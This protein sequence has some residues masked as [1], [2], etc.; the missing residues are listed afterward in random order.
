MNKKKSNLRFSDILRGIYGGVIGSLCCVL[1]LVAVAAGLGFIPGIMTTPRYRIYF[2]AAGLILVLFLTWR[3]VRSSN[4]DTYRK[5][6]ILFTTLASFFLVVILF[7]YLITPI[8]SNLIAKY[9]HPNKN[10]PVSNSVATKSTELH[11]VTLKITGLTCPSCSSVIEGLVSK[12]NGV[13]KVKV[14]ATTGEGKVTYNINLVSKE[15]IA[16]AVEGQGTVKTAYKAKIVK[17][18]KYTQH[19]KD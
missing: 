3:R 12:V 11:L 6:T 2:I 18:E 17:D 19:L 5:L 7:T 1:P 16:K 10:Q 9:S 14:N 15:E 4:M 8:T 13:R